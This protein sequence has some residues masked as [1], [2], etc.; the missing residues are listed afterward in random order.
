[1]PE[2]PRPVAVP[3][4]SPRLHL[5]SGAPFCLQSRKSPIMFVFSGKPKR[6]STKAH[7]DWQEHPQ[8]PRSAGHLWCH[9]LV[10][11][12]P[13][14]EDMACRKSPFRGSPRKLPEPPG[15]QKTEKVRK[16]SA[17]E[18]ISHTVPT[19]RSPFSW[20]HEPVGTTERKSER[21][22][23]ETIPGSLSGLAPEAAGHFFPEEGGTSCLSPRH[24]ALP[25]TRTGVKVGTMLA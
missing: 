4:S 22:F 18:A 23:S 10:R 19:V 8:W 24:A 21:T 2:A 5:M 20:R 15:P 13:R 9:E 3:P 6:A 25:L 1:M 14:W 12:R 16:T 11:W 17:C 7:H